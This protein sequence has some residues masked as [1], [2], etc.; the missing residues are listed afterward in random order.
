MICNH[1]NTKIVIIELMIVRFVSA[2]VVLTFIK[3]N[4]KK[5]NFQAGNF[6]VPTL[7]PP[8]WAQSDVNTMVDGST[9][10]GRKLG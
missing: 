2:L 10:P 9:Y 7:G 1:Y 6:S 5:T 8:N 3:V 4:K